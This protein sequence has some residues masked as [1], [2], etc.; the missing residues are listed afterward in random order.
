MGLKLDD[1][2]VMPNQYSYSPEVNWT[3]LSAAFQNIN[4]MLHCFVASSSPHGYVNCVRL[5]NSFLLL[6]LLVLQ[7]KCRTPLCLCFMSQFSH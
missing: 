5:R 2:E 1:A 4:N 3:A 6:I 7:S